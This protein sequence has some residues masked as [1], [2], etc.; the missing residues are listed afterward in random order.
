MIL[1]VFLCV[2][3]ILMRKWL[4]AMQANSPCFVLFN[5]LSML[6]LSIC[7]CILACKKRELSQ[8][9]NK[10]LSPLV[11]SFRLMKLK[12]KCQWPAHYL[13]VWRSCRHLP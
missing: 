10:G 2:Q 11:S 4:V 5:L 13:E 6:D 12:L 1:S 7:D 9:N 3:A 8:T